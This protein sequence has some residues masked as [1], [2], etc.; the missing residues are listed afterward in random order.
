[1]SLPLSL[2]EAQTHREHLDQ[3]CST[4]SAGLQDSHINHHRV[5]ELKH[6]ALLSW[7]FFF[8]F[9]SPV[10]LFATPWTI[11]S[12]E[13]SGQNT[14]VGRLS[15]LQ[16]IFP[17]QGSNPGLPPCRQVLYQLSHQ[18]SP[19]KV[20][21]VQTPRHQHPHFVRMQTPGLPAESKDTSILASLPGRP[22]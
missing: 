16:G 3:P 5:G 4:E 14:G 1:M 22:S 8:C 12:M 13:F 9:E 19:L 15:L 10:P 7:F 11:Q 2:V 21:K 20:L 18:G 17:T 6:T